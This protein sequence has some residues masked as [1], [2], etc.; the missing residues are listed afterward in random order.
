MPGENIGIQ[1]GYFS[2]YGLAIAALDVFQ[3]W[4]V[5]YMESDARRIICCVVLMGSENATPWW[6]RVHIEAG[7]RHPGA[8]CPGRQDARV[9]AHR[10]PEAN[11]FTQ[12]LDSVT[13]LSALNLRL[14]E[15]MTLPSA[16]QSLDLFSQPPWLCR[17]MQSLAFGCWWP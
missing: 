13:L 8:E 1:G 15:A 9:E 7:W 12:P 4:F 10:L 16:L 14:G 11:L 5:S 3:A 6:R 17:S 2:F